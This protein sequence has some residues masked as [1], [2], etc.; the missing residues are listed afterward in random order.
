LTTDLWQAAIPFVPGHQFRILISQPWMSKAYWVRFLRNCTH[1]PFASDSA[2]L[3][4]GR[5]E[6]LRPGVVPQQAD[7]S[8]SHEP[9]AKFCYV[10]ETT[11]AHDVDQIT[12]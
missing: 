11:P 3:N 9:D 1:K 2:A 7:D 10:I 8:K 12:A 6:R 5:G 4:D